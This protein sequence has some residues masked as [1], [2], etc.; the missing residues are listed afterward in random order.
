M[1]RCSEGRKGE[2]GY[3]GGRHFGLFA[4]IKA[5]R[6]VHD[7]TPRAQSLVY[8]ALASRKTF[9]VQRAC[10]R[11]H[12]SISHPGHLRKVTTWNG[13]LACITR[14]RHATARKKA[15]KWQ[16][17]KKLPWQSN[18]PIKFLCFDAGHNFAQRRFDVC[19]GR[20]FFTT[21][22]LVRKLS[23]CAA[24]LMFGPKSACLLLMI[25]FK[26]IALWE[27]LQCEVATSANYFRKAQLIREIIEG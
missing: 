13:S 21:P 18:G 5:A 4:K 10:N 7:V 8:T 25:Q 12:V 6:R 9:R 26:L 11:P 23:W 2:E 22:T 17:E 19:F 27:L 16:G 20:I 24:N 3:G 15:V 14:R 1:I